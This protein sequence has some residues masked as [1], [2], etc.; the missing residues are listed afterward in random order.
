MFQYEGLQIYSIIADLLKVI[1]RNTVRV[2][3]RQERIQDAPR[4][5]V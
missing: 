5:A 3:R 2:S 1:F 4:I